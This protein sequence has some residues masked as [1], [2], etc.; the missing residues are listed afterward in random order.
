MISTPHSIIARFFYLAIIFGTCCFSGKAEDLARGHIVRLWPI[1][2]VG[3]ETNRL[4]E[5]YRERRPGVRQLCGVKDPN[6]T[7]YPAQSPEP[8]PAVIYSPGGGYGI[9]GI[10]D[11]ATIQAWNDLGI[12]LIVLKYTIPKRYDAAFQ[13]IQRA[14][15]LVRHHAAQWNIDPDRI[16]LFGNSAGGHLSARL[17]NNYD[18]PAY[19][20]IDAIDK[21]SCE[22]SFAIL[23]CSAYFNGIPLNKDKNAKLDPTY[24]HLNNQVAPTFLTYA[25]DDPHYPGGTNYTN[26]MKKAGYPIHFEVYDTGGHG[27]KECDWFAQA[28]QWLKDN[29][30]ISVAPKANPTPLASKV[31]PYEGPE[32]EKA[33]NNPKDNPELPNVLLIGDSIS[34]GY[35]VPVRKRLK[36]KA[37]VFRCPTNA[38]MSTY[39]LKQLD[40]WIGDR[41]WDVIHFNWGLW[42][43]CYRHPESKVQ[44]NRDKINGA[45]TTTPEDYQKTMAKII[46]KLL[47]N[48]ATLIWCETTPVPAHEAGRKLGDEIIYN[49]IVAKLIQGK[50]IHTNHLHAHALTALP[51]IMIKEGDV[52]FTPE[53]YDHLADQVARAIEQQLDKLEFN[54][55]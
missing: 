6:L 14:V 50:A 31:E 55:L 16:G 18:Q 17:M 30:F 45:L 46:A 43:I 27:M 10:P 15:R 13:D 20:P 23:Q 7:L 32:Y 24:F 28:S 53:G 5:E 42:D 12:T 47:T 52:H 40:N 21:H 4:K 38:R 8:T 36:G 49:Q 54:P 11:D 29:Q 48:D 39:G 37:D 25:K 1:E 35:T 2:R 34:I 9:L 19:H 51:A 41:D 44:G 3:G 26:A 22:P 33:F